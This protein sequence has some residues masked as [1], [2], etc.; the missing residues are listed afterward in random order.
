MNVKTNSECDRK[1]CELETCSST[2]ATFNLT[3]EGL[4]VLGEA[5]LWDLNDQA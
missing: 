4:F 1:Q 2:Y 5:N 3:L